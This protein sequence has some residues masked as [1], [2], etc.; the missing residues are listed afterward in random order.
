[1]KKLMFTLAICS[2]VFTSA[3]AQKQLGKEHNVEVNL[4]P[5]GTVL[6]DGTFAGP[7]D[8]TTFKYRY[9][10]DD[11]AALRVSLTVGV[12]SNVFA[13][14]QAGEAPSLSS[15]GDDIN[16]PQ[17]DYH[18]SNSNFGI[19]LG[20]EKHFSGT[21]NLSPYIGFEGYY[22]SGSVTHMKEYWGAEKP[23]DQ[24]SAEVFETWVLQNQQKHSSYGASLFLGADYYFSDAIYIGFEAGFGIGMTKFKD[25]EIY[26]DNAGAY[27]TLYGTIDLTTSG[28]QILDSHTGELTFNVLDDALYFNYYEGGNVDGESEPNHI[29]NTS[30]GNVFNSAIRVGFLFD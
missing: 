3:Q 18:T 11:D 29:S 27:N 10:I 9:F 19:G 21:D 30:L 8:G 15:V 23:A 6:T 4:N 5:F 28:P 22:A 26:T 2:L 7:I 20:Y 14:T 24:G 17:L 1:M 13:Y 16:N 12:S 25:H